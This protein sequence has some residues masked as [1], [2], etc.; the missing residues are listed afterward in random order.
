[1]KVDW[2]I[3]IWGFYISRTWYFFL[4][5]ISLF[6]LSCSA[7]YVDIDNPSRRVDLNCFSITL[8]VNGDWYKRSYYVPELQD[9]CENEARF[10]SGNEEGVYFI[11]FES[12]IGDWKEEFSNKYLLDKKVQELEDEQ[13]EILKDNRFGIEDFRYNVEVVSGIKDISVKSKTTYSSSK[14]NWHGY[15]G[16]SVEFLKSTLKPSDR[17]YYEFIELSVIEGPYKRWIG[18]GAIIYRVI[19]YHISVNEDG[20]PELEEN[21]LKFLENLEFT[22]D[23]ERVDKD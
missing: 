17:Y 4:F 11:G 23:W 9:K 10:A 19:F 15:G 7:K 2:H 22:D 1:M 13:N 5:S 20:D 8:P 18:Q 16:S 21:S 14:P 3:S 12:Y 6:I